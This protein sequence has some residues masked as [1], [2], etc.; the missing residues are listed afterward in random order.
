MTKVLI[1]VMLISSHVLA[2]S[3]GSLRLAGYVPSR[4]FVNNIEISDSG[5]FLQ[6]SLSKNTREI[7]FRMLLEPV[8]KRADNVN[9]RKFFILSQLDEKQRIDLR[10]F[11]DNVQQLKMTI[12]SP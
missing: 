11:K 8:K 2:G 6:L 3:V 10:P 5:E 4:A 1:A 9:W 7:N 12:V